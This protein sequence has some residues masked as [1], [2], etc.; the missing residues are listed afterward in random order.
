[1][2]KSQQQWWYFGCEGQAGHYLFDENMTKIWGRKYN[3]LRALDGLLPP[4]EDKTPYIATFSRLDGWGVCAI[5]FWDYSV[6]KRGGSNSTFF[7][8]DLGIPPSVMFE[9]VKNRFSQL[10]KRFPKEITLC[11]VTKSNETRRHE[12][13]SDPER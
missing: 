11:D 10:F 9:E 5:A 12:D 8:S 1:M 2:N 3:Y 6:D 4:Q 7:V 13:V